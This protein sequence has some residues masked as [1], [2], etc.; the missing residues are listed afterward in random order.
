MRR[1]PVCLRLESKPCYS[2]AALLPPKT[3]V[4]YQHG[5]LIQPTTKASDN[6]FP[7]IA[8]CRPHHLTR[9]QA[10]RP[11]VR[12]VEP[13]KEVYSSK[14]KMGPL[15]TEHLGLPEK[16]SQGFQGGHMGWERG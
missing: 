5:I 3:G 2:C 10:E 15:C 1:T 6:T 8:E 16:K 12:P 11:A 13:M 9:V 7:S 4:C 14:Q